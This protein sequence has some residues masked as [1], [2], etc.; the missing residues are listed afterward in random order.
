VSET[1]PPPKPEEPVFQTVVPAP[2]YEMKI[3]VKGIEVDLVDDPPPT[4]P[5]GV[6]MPRMCVHN[7]NPDTCPGCEADRELEEH[8]ELL[9]SKQ[10]PHDFGCP[11]FVNENWTEAQ[12]VNYER[13]YDNGG[14]CNCKKESK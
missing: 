5:T 6:V 4:L 3:E 9:I 13:V 7:Q 11:L 10:R 1:K 2:Q 8:P 14:G 12:H